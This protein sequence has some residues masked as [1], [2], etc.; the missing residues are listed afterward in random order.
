MYKNTSGTLK[1][2]AFN[3][4]TSQ[5]QLGDAANISC[6]VSVNGGARAALTQSTPIELEDGYYVF[7]VQASENNGATV[8]FFPESSTANIQVIPIEH[9]RYTRDT[10][11]TLSENISAQIISQLIGRF[12]ISSS[13]TGAV[14]TAISP[15]V[16][17]EEIEKLG[18]FYVGAFVQYAKSDCEIVITIHPSAKN[19]TGRLVWTAKPV[20]NG[21]QN[22]IVIQVDSA[23]GLVTPSGGGIIA[24]DAS[25]VGLVDGTNPIRQVRLKMYARALSLLTPGRLYWDIRRYDTSPAAAWELATGV[26]DFVE[27]VN[28]SV[29]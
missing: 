6:K 17:R 10:L 7:N 18:P 2:F 28:Q 29:T 27:P 13:V 8:D 9:A 21:A 19:A 15:V 22:T 25:V 5:P 26:I 1:V 16:T 3:R 20:I 4:N 23:T 12:T 24:A 14:T 11:T